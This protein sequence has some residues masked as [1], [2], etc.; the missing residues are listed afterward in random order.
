[1][2][3]KTSPDVAIAAVGL[4][5]VVA[6]LVLFGLL[7]WPL[8][9]PAVL[10]ATVLCPIALAR[11]IITPRAFRSGI[12]WSLP[13]F[14]IG[15]Y[16]VVTAANRAGLNSL[17]LATMRG[18]DHS[19][20]GILAIIAAT[21]LSSNLVNNLPAALAAIVGLASLPA[22]GREGAAFATLIGTNLGPQITVFGSLATMLVLH[23]GRRVGIRVPLRSYFL[24]GVLTIPPMLLTAGVV[25]WLELR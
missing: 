20:G 10:G 5:V 16:T 19:L 13:P 22:P 4:A 1:V 8:A 2:K 25:L 15:M 24:V 21:G 23:A 14:V 11:R 17:L 7:G 6:G 12:A 18:D 3:D 9:I